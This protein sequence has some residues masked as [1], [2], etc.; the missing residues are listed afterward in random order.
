[1]L[2]VQSTVGSAVRHTSEGLRLRERE[3]QISELNST[4][5]NCYTVFTL[6]SRLY[7]R[8]GELCK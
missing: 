6:Y 8:L 1:M 2:N 7:N 5:V 3:R 4:E